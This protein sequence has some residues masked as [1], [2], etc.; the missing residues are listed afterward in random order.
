M[1]VIELVPYSQGQ[2]W[3]PSIITTL[4]VTSFD[5]PPFYGGKRKA[6]FGFNEIMWQAI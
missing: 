5:L 2:T 3:R 4:T 1:S 6:N